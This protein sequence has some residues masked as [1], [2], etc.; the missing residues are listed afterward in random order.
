MTRRDERQVRIV[1]GAI[2]SG[3]DKPGR[4][5]RS[6]PMGI[7]LE[8]SIP[9]HRK[10]GQTKWERGPEFKGCCFRRIWRQAPLAESS[11]SIVR[12]R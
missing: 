3:Q 11:P 8:T 7:T 4:T 6:S 12:S 5:P 9:E 2:T 10:S 1:P